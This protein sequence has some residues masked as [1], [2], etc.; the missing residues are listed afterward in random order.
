MRLIAALLIAVGITAVR[1]SA[2]ELVRHG[3]EINVRTGKGIQHPSVAP[4]PDG[5]FV[6]VWSEP[7]SNWDAPA[8]AA[9]LTRMSALSPSGFVLRSHKN[10]IAA[11]LDP[12]GQLIHGPIVVNLTPTGE[13]TLNWAPQVAAAADGTTIIAWQNWDARMILGRLYDAQGHPVSGEMQL[14]VQPIRYYL[15]DVAAAATASG[16]FVV[17]WNELDDTLPYDRHL[18]AGR[19]VAAN[20]FLG[21]SFPVSPTDSPVHQI[22]PTILPLGGTT[23]LAVWFDDKGEQTIRARILGEEPEGAAFDIA[24]A[25][26][27]RRPRACILSSGELLFAWEGYQSSFIPK[28]RFSDRGAW[29]RKYGPTGDP[30]AEPLP[31][32]AAND[33]VQHVAAVVCLPESPPTF[34]IDYNN[35]LIGRSLEG[36]VLTTQF[37]IPHLN[38]GAADAASMGVQDFVVV[39]TDCFDPYEDEEPDC[40]LRAQRFSRDALRACPGD[41]NLNGQVTIDE[42]ILA[43]RLA[44]A[45]TKSGTNAC[46]PADQNLDYGIDISELVAAVGRSLEGCGS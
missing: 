14:N 2:G 45:S 16:G 18:L 25:L 15:G 22:H 9:S 34:V 19:P 1:S 39:W 26:N 35:V 5:G 13:T 36:D 24:G 41:C 40:T 31:I 6:I 30:L 12:A 38:G 3:G 4:L 21:D 17:L 28:D 44:L 10:V 33:D 23:L 37:V 42:L 8:A 29:F 7:I 27:E 11:W 43:T 20:G 46:L 32:L